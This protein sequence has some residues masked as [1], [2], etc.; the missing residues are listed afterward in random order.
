MPALHFEIF[1]ISKN[2]YCFGIICTIID[3]VCTLNGEIDFHSV[4]KNNVQ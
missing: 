2:G 4:L 3:F 1:E